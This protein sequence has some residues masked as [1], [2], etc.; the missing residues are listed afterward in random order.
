MQ[1]FLSFCIACGLCIDFSAYAENSIKQTEQID[2]SQ[3]IDSNSTV[4]NQFFVNL[5]PGVRVS[6]EPAQQPLSSY[7][8]LDKKTY[9]LGLSDHFKIKGLIISTRHYIADE[10]ADIAP[11]DIVLGWKKMSDP[12]ILKH[13]NVRQNNRFYYWHV[14]E[15]PL[16]RAE[17][18]LSSTNI[19]L[20]PNT[21]AIEAGLKKLKKGT[22]V[23]LTGY[24]V[25]VKSSDGFIWSTSRT[26]DDSGDGA[27]EILLVKQIRHLK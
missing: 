20:I 23:E 4:S 1:K 10:R 14:S 2:F 11:I 15:F 21:K 8:W 7:K 9:Q 22:V 6:S 19:H 25:D 3:N 26:R 12:T 27:C 5:A 16:P 17:L 13:I 24:L 18:E